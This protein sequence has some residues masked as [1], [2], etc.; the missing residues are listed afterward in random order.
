MS[1]TK[2]AY[3]F[4]FNCEELN[5]SGYLILATKFPLL[6]MPSFKDAQSKLL[7]R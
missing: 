3:H 7:H 4:Y 6:H 5:G 2:K 1:L